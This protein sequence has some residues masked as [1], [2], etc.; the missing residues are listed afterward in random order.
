MKA[1]V[2]EPKMAIE[3]KF[4]EIQIVRNLCNLVCISNELLSTYA[5]AGDM[6]EVCLRCDPKRAGDWRYFKQLDNEMA[7]TVDGIEDIGFKALFFYFAY[8]HKISEDFGTGQQIPVTEI[9]NV[10]SEATVD[11]VLSYIRYI[12]DEGQHVSPFRLTDTHRDNWATLGRH[13]PQFGG[14]ECIANLD[15]AS[16]RND[17]RR[18]SNVPQPENP[19][20]VYG[21]GQGTLDFTPATV[22]DEA[23]DLWVRSIQRTTLYNDYVQYCIRNEEKHQKMGYFYT[24]LG[25]VFGRSYDMSRNS[26]NCPQK[27]VKLY[28]PEVTNQKTEFIFAYRHKYSRNQVNT[29]YVILPSLEDARSMY[30][31]K[32]RMPSNP[33]S[34][35]DNL[36]EKRQRNNATVKTVSMSCKSNYEE[37]ERFSKPCIMT[38][39]NHE[40]KLSANLR[41]REYIGRDGALG[42]EQV[43]YF[44]VK[45][46]N[47]KQ[48]KIVRNLTN[49]EFLKTREL[50][51]HEMQTSVTTVAVPRPPS[52]LPPSPVDHRAEW[53]PLLMTREQY[54]ALNAETQLVIP[55]PIVHTPEHPV[56]VNLYALHDDQM[57]P[58]VDS[59]TSAVTRRLQNVFIDNQAIAEE[60]SDF[61]SPARY[62]DE[63]SGSAQ[64]TPLGH[65]AHDILSNEALSGSS[66]D[67]DRT[68]DWR[69][70]VP[71][72]DIHRYNTDYSSSSDSWEDNITPK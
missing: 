65:N 6:R 69:D 16:D 47:N 17:L 60:Y 38:L 25:E 52:P 31:M 13:M 29:R 62:S 58:L 15:D 22:I 18:Q 1:F 8:D 57:P 19:F 37:P 63:H 53:G 10:Q 21:Q 46:I 27:L 11:N 7:A 51:P 44:A 50:E 71:Q 9:Q 54:D 39:Y 41:R 20:V 59:P 66:K 42:I 32:M 26:T 48:N 28:N 61:D 4:E 23:M 67:Y 68:K 64:S 30:A 40:P 12:L 36:S 24:K 35:E 70:L 33:W 3:A 14:R 34:E 55:E 43:N 5:D 72:D 49:I 45:K 2:T 56:L